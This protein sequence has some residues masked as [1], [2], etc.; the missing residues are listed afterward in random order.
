MT[1][2]ALIY[3]QLH[4]VDRERHL[5]WSIKAGDDCSFAREVNSVP[6][7]S[8]EFARA[9]ENYPIIFAGTKDNVLP[10]IVLGLQKNQNLFIS[11]EGK[12]DYL[13]AFIR[14]YPFVFS[15]S[16][17]KSTFILC[18]DEDFSGCNQE[19]RGERLFDS[20]GKQTSYLN[21][22]VNFLK[23]YQRSHQATTQFCSRIVELDLLE[24]VRATYTGP[25]AQPGVLTGFYAVKRE[26]IKE[27]DDEKLAE[28][29]KSDG[30]E[31]IYWHLLSLNKFK[32][33]AGR[34]PPAEPATAEPATAEPTTEAETA[35]KASAPEKDEK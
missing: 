13:P 19:G 8:A 6:L 25:N 35:E 24:E 22:V 33:L 14:R 28:L 11:E 34:L 5:N 18:I 27:L 29:V 2:Q 3:D 26:K 20:E 7:L 31:L 32:A 4:A 21:G 23:D 15:Q 10:C 9:A 30:M 1:T 16:E 17:D 12:W